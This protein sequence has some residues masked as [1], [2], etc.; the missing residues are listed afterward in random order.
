MLVG[1][2]Y[3]FYEKYD[4]G[5]TDLTAFHEYTFYMK[6]IGNKVDIEAFIFEVSEGIL[7][8]GLAGFIFGVLTGTLLW[9]WL[10]QMIPTEMA[11]VDIFFA[12]KAGLWNGAVLG[13]LLA[14]YWQLQ[15]FLR[16]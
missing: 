2:S 6:R 9:I 5:L 13:G 8:G 10:W 7:I 1:Y 11:L 15:L 4:Y 12:G 3:T 14:V 16:D